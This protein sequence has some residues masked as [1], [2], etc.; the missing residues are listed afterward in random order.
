M[1]ESFFLSIK[2]LTK[3]KAS[4]LIDVSELLK[5]GCHRNACKVSGAQR[6]ELSIKEQQLGHQ[7]IQLSYRANRY[8]LCSEVG[9]NIVKLKPEQ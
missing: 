9:L 4:G 8:I 7:V 3:G 5:T 1:S 6:C 2:N